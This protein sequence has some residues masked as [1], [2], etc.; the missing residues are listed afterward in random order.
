METAFIVLIAVVSVLLVFLIIIQNSKG[1]G[2]VS[3]IRPV[4]ETAQLFGVRQSADVV[5]RL[6]WYMMGILATLVV[7][8]NFIYAFRAQQGGSTQLRIQEQLDAQ[9]INANPTELPELAPG[10]EGAPAETPA[11]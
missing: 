9:P 6:S 10:A 5:T 1:G 8:L 11:P 2:L 3:N 7:T 4:S